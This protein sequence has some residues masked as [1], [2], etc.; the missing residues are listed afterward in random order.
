MPPPQNC[1]NRLMVSINLLPRNVQR[2]IGKIS[3]KPLWWLREMLSLKHFGLIVKHLEF[4]LFQA[5]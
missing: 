3:K 1:A 4:L 2:I 5:K